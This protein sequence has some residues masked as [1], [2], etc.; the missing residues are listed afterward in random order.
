MPILARFQ[1]NQLYSPQLTLHVF[2]HCV[3]MGHSWVHSIY[4][5]TDFVNRWLTVSGSKPACISGLKV[6]RMTRTMWVTN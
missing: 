2:E 6:G 3:N 5:D 4:R 1:V